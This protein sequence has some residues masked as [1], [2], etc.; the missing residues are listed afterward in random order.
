VTDTLASLQAAI[1]AEPDDARAVELAAD[2]LYAD[3]LNM[4]FAIM[5]AETPPAADDDDPP[6][7]PPAAAAMQH[8]A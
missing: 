7:S 8:A 2:A 6:S 4:M 5:D 3:P 1:E